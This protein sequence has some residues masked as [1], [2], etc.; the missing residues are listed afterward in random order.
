MTSWNFDDEPPD[1][2]NCS[3]ADKVF[4][5]PVV[6]CDG[7][8]YERCFPGLL[9]CARQRRMTGSVLE[10]RRSEIEEW[11]KKGNMTSPNTGL[12]PL[13][14]WLR[15]AEGKTLETQAL[16]P[17]HSLR[18]VTEEWRAA[19]KNR[20]GFRF[21]GAEVPSSSPGNT[22][23]KRRRPEP[24]FNKALPASSRS[25]VFAGGGKE[26][27]RETAVDQELMEM[28]CKHR[29]QG[30]AETL[31]VKGGVEIVAD[32]HLL[33]EEDVK[34]LELP[35]VQRKRVLM[36][37][38]EVKGS[39]ALEEGIK[40]G[41]CQSG[42]IG[43]EQ[44]EGGANVNPF[45]EFDHDLTAEDSEK[46]VAGSWTPQKTKN[47]MHSAQ[48]PFQ[49]ARSPSAATSRSGA[50]PAVKYAGVNLRRR[51]IKVSIFTVDNCKDK[52][53]FA[54]ITASRTHRGVLQHL[55]TWDTVGEDDE[56]LDLAKETHYLFEEGEEEVSEV[57]EDDDESLSECTEV[58]QHVESFTK[59]SN[60]KVELSAAASSKSASAPAHFLL[61]GFPPPRI[62]LL[63]SPPFDPERDDSDQSS[64]A[65][66]S[67]DVPLQLLAAG[68]HSEQQLST[69]E[70]SEEA[71]GDVQGKDNC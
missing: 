66:P 13:T 19:H 57:S 20:C 1:G 68:S 12:N 42:E 37:L 36:L 9:E 17:N 50:K 65:R 67:L 23:C 46:G 10:C 33:D 48:R 56:W 62:S 7:Q 45:D 47:R 49:A 25:V 54:T 4:E 61:W 41:S 27:D 63:A 34:E 58:K 53:H 26:H 40:E 32:L 2:L 29:L 69:V 3:I 35:I 70:V 64:L 43:R 6:T 51:R 30:I 24:F 15:L 38:D 18:K 59:E 16:V 22:G 39:F 31:R 44:G 55:V 71:A 14:P 5:D 28:L 11:F 8:S 21:D 60:G 52:W